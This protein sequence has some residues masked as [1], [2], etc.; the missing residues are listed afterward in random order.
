MH[1]LEYMFFPVSQPFYT[2]A[3]WSNLVADVFWGVAAI[4]ISKIV[5]RI[6]RKQHDQHMVQSE[7]YQRQLL[8]QIQALNQQ[9][10]SSD[11]SASSDK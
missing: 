1:F 6:I 5:I 11:V 8:E 2:G 9:L 4:S 10:G 7:V 3:F